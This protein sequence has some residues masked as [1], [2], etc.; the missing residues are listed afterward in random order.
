MSD[1]EM[2]PAQ[3]AVLVDADKQRRVRAAA[4]AVQA[5]LAEYQCD[6]VAMPQITPDGRIVAVVQI[7]AR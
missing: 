5:A 6:L 1:E 7:V 2:T 4:D 3:A